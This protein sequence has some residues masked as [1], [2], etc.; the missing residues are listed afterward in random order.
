MFIYGYDRSYFSQP[1]KKLRNLQILITINLSTQVF[2]LLHSI[3]SLI[4]TYVIKKEKEDWIKEN[5]LYNSKYGSQCDVI[6]TNYI[7][8]G[9]IYSLDRICFHFIWQWIMMYLIWPKK[10]KTKLPAKEKDQ[11]SSISMNS[12]SLSA[13][14]Q[15]GQDRLGLA[16]D[17]A[18]NYSNLISSKGYT[19]DTGEQSIER[20]NY[21]REKMKEITR[22]NIKIVNKSPKHHDKK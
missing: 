11:S 16:S 14:S 13:T 22:L 9:F 18:A 8:D 10:V 2:C 12:S 20:E 4:W 5:E 21:Q 7:L 19:D 6:T 3:T 17:F 15:I 1:I